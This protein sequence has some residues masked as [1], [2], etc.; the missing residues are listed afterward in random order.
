MIARKTASDLAG[1]TVAP[2]LRPPNPVSDGRKVKKEAIE[3]E[4]RD[5]QAHLTGSVY[6]GEYPSA[7]LI[8][9]DDLSDRNRSHRGD[10]RAEVNR[11][12]PVQTGGAIRLPH[13]VRA[14]RIV[15]KGESHCGKIPSGR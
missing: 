15:V 9:D 2:G 11:L 14:V 8:D 3:K 5:P 13:T 10:V 4:C 6:A 1:V 12:H 7:P